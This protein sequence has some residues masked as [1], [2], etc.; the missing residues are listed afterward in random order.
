MQDVP[1]KVKDRSPR[2]VIV[3]VFELTVKGKDGQIVTQFNIKFCA[4]ARIGGPP[5]GGPP[6]II[7]FFLRYLIFLAF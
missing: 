6:T 3:P 1:K 2:E 5:I 4:R 7:I